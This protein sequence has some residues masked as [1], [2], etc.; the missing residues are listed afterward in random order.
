MNV[1]CDWHHGGLYYSLVRLFEDRLGWKL[2]RPTG[3][4][5]YTKRFWR[6]SDNPGT[7][8]QYLEPSDDAAGLKVGQVRPAAVR[9]D[10]VYEWPWHEGENRFTM[11]AVTLEAFKRMDWHFVVASVWNHEEPFARLIREHAPRAVLIRQM[12]NIHDHFDEGT[13]KNVLNS[14]MHEV[15]AGINTVRYHQEFDLGVYR[16]QPPESTKIV[17]SFLHA[18]A[19]TEPPQLVSDH[20][21]F[22]AMQKA[23][24]DFVFKCHGVLNEDGNLPSAEI[25]E[26]VRSTAF[27]CHLKFWGDGFGHTGFSSAACGKPLITKGRYFQ[28]MM[29]G[30]LLE[31]GK[32]FVDIGDDVAANVEKLRYWAEP[33]RYAELS[34][35]MR[36]RFL[37]VVDYDAEFREIRAFLDRAQNIVSTD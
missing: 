20:Q 11:R 18:F 30:E 32:T 1:F 27:T 5:W 2:Y 12:G 6:Y 21:L 24:P 37:R 29:L 35:N 13:T 22:H 26:A 36:E 9:P 33:S 25:P 7:I 17:K 16:P 19:T 34:R 8:R 10:G 31:D 14:T 15:P 23:M 3:F 28:G 4:D